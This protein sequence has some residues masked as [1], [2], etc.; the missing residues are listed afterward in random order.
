MVDAQLDFPLL[1]R[2]L[3]GAEIIDVRIRDVIR[4]TK[5]AVV[6]PGLFLAADD[7]LG[8]VIELLVGVSHQTG[9]EDVIVIPAAVEADQVE[10]HQ[11][12]NLL[13]GGIDHPHHRRP[14]A[15][16]L[17][18]HQ[19]QVG[20]DLHVVE[21][22][23]GLV[24]LRRGRLIVGLELHPVDQFD[25]ILGFVAAVG[26]EG[27]NSV[28]HIRHIIDEAAVIAVLQDLIDKV[29]AGLS[30]GMDLLIEILPDLSSKPFLA[31]DHFIVYH[32]TF[33]FQR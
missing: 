28:A 32:F 11:F 7:A 19:E 16:E 21:H 10:L 30:I 20:E 3:F 18:V 26:R 4:L 12:L 33:S 23:L 9:V 6:A 31:L 8:Q 14:R 5:E 29:D 17:P 27:Q 22:Q 13:G 1:Q 15:L 2:L 25:A 24:V